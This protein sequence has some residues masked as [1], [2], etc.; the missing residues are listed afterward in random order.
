VAGVGAPVATRPPSPRIS[1]ALNPGYG[2][3]AARRGASG[4]QRTVS[5]PWPNS[6]ARACASLTTGAALTV[7]ASA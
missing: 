6:T 3:Y 7:A 1:L 5:L 2:S 4:A